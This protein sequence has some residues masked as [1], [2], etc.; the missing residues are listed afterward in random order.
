MRTVYPIGTTVYDPK[1]CWNG[2]TILNSYVRGGHHSKERIMQSGT[3]GGAEQAKKV[4]VD[5][6]SELEINIIDMNG[7]IINGWDTLA[8]RNP[9][10]LSNGNLLVAG[11][12]GRKTLGWFLEGHPTEYDWEGN[13]VWEAFPPVEPHGAGSVALRLENGNTLFYYKIFLPDEFRLRIEDPEQRSKDGILS[14]CIA[15]VTSGGKVVWDW[16]S[17]E[18]L[19]LNAWCKNDPNPNWTHFNNL[20]AL[21]E[22]RWY[23][24]G[25][26]RFKPG[27]ILVSGRTLGFIFIVSKETGEIVW[28]YSGDHLGGLAGQHS[29]YMI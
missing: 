4:G 13:L 20:Q 8:F 15:E 14:D 1:K 23:D 2:Y 3:E 12:T 29:P 7:S 11:S 18:H 27:N 28:R 19:D 17:H 9:K 24:E 26:E 5:S 22:N 10:L 21:P 16:R 6:K 25:D